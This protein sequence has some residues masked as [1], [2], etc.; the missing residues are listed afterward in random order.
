M[1]KQANKDEID[2]VELLVKGVLL[3]KHN[4]IQIIVFFV[5]GSGLGFTYAS[6]APKVYE[7]KMIVSSSILSESYCKKLFETLNTLIKEKNYKALSAKLKATEAEVEELGEFQIES[8]N[9][10][11]IISPDKDNTS[12]LVSVKLTNKNLLPFIQSGLIGYLQNNDFVRIRVEHNKSYI[13]Q[14]IA[15]VQKEIESLENFKSSVYDG[16]FFQSVKGGVMFDPTTVNTK[17]IDL[18]K[19]KINLEQSL[20]MVNSVEIINGFTKF[21]KPIWPK[22]SVSMVA[23]ATF[24]LFLVGLLIAIKSIRKLVKF[25]EEHPSSVKSAS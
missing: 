3:V 25:A 5:I 20:E 9:E 15:K 14:M 7:S 4:I 2:L 12:F 6:L 1:E 19:E 8:L 16:K 23:G 18:T 24:G 10:K 11:L 22:K 21:D 17:I 13:K